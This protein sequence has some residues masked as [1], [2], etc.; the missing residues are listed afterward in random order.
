MLQDSVISKQH[1]IGDVLQFIETSDMSS[2]FPNLRQLYK[3][4]TIMPVSSASAERSFSRLKLIK[5]Y[6]RSKMGESRLSDL[7][8]LSI[9]RNISEN[10]DFNNVIQTFANMKSRRKKLV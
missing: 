5:S 6:T 9:E 10:L 7:A 1:K 8:L 3:I 2:V 4:Y